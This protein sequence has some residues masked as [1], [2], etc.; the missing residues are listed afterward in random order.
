MSLQINSSQ[1]LR[2]GLTES[3]GDICYFCL[4][5]DSD[6]CFNVRIC[7]GMYNYSVNRILKSQNKQMHSETLK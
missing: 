1:N 4:K 6:F 5:W 2:R 7:I 3:L